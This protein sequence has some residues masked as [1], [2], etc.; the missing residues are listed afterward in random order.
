MPPIRFVNLESYVAGVEF[1]V[2]AG[3]DSQSYV[4]QLLGCS[5]AN[6]TEKICRHFVVRIGSK[7]NQF[8]LKLFV[9]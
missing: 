4:P 3:T 6:H 8:Q 2:K 5:G 7:R 1:D 9:S